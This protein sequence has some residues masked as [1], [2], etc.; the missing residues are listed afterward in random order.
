MRAR[1]ASL[2]ARSRFVPAWPSHSAIVE[3]STPAWLAC[4]YVELVLLR[5]LG[6]TGRISN[7][8]EPDHWVGQTVPAPWANG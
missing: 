4:W 5:R 2:G 3:V 8:L 1:A 6:Y 7:R